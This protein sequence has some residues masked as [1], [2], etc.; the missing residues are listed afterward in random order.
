M[1]RKLKIGVIGSLCNPNSGARTSIDLSIALS[2]L[3]HQVILYTYANNADINMI[4]KLKKSG[5]TLHFVKNSVLPIFSVLIEASQLISK[6]REDKPDILLTHTTLSLTI[7]AKSSGIPCIIT[8]YGTQFNVLKEQYLNPSTA[9]NFLDTL[10]NIYIYIKSFCLV[11][12]SKNVV[13]ISKYC[14][15]ELF[16]MYHKNSHVIYLAAGSEY[17]VLN[18]HSTKKIKY[19]VKL[20]T[21]SRITPYKQFHKLI[22]LLKQI[23]QRK[24]FLTIAG[25]SPKSTYLKYLHDIKPSN[26]KIVVNASAYK[27][28]KMYNECDIYISADKYLFFGLPIMEAASYQRPTI[29]FNYGAAPELIVHGKTGYVANT[30]PEYKKYISELIENPIKRIRMGEK[31]KARSQLFDW[32]KTARAYVYLSYQTIK[33]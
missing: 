23:D 8:Y 14:K 9:I 31:A 10:I 32:E 26:V 21:V 12:L 20:L 29:C 27:L 25:S 1:I 30:W 2:K 4:G 22:E 28:A 18:I 19:P 7:S 11:H 3:N 13:S 6:L 24:A 5:V 33:A 17:F 15:N 16:S